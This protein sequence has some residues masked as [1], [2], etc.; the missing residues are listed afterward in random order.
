MVSRPYP[1]DPD[2]PIAVGRKSF[3]NEHTGKQALARPLLGAFFFL[4]VCASIRGEQL[5]IKTYTTSDG[6]PRNVINRIVRDSHGFLW[7]CTAEGLSRFDGYAFTNYGVKQGLP[8]RDVRDLIETHSGEYW[9]ATHNGMARFNPNA[10]P[11]NSAQGKKEDGT[12]AEPEPRFDTYAT[13]W[14]PE[15]RHVMALLE[16]RNGTMWCGTPAG[17]CQLKRLTANG[18]SG[19]WTSEPR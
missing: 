17:L 6:L 10:V 7:F 12:K 16:D 18:S 4:T 8:D 14:N 13:N 9:V 1:V 15:A 5:P 2:A 11:A 19:W 3:Q